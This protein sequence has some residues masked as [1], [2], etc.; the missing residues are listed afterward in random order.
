MAILVKGTNDLERYRVALIL[1]VSDGV[2]IL[3]WHSVAKNPPLELQ[4][5]YVFA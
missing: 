4:D 5:V 3:P 2:L 1:I